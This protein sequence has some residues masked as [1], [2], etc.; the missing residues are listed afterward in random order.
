MSH[1]AVGIAIHALLTDE[2]LRDR[3]AA[4]P[5]EALADLNIRG[6]ALTTDEI[7]MFLRTDARV[8]IWRHDVTGGRVH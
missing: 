8:W 6:V 1:H 3:F 2:E 4:D 5:I 7:D